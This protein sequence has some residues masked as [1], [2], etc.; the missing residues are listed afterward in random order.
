[1]DYHGK[2]SN[3]N[4]TSITPINPQG[5]AIYH[6]NPRGGF[7]TT[8]ERKLAQLIPVLDEHGE[9]IE[10]HFVSPRDMDGD[11][12]PDIYVLLRPTANSKY[13]MDVGLFDEEAAPPPPPAQPAPTAPATSSQAILILSAT[14]AVSAAASSTIP[15]EPTRS[16]AVQQ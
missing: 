1:M 6:Q 14:S 7:K 16:T 4:N 2:K 13:M 10:D 5:R 3:I 9:V 11:G 8:K 15:T 12:V